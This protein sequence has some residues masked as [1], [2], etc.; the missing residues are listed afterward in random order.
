M[1]ALA[2]LTR[3]IFMI[4]VMLVLAIAAAIELCD[5]FKRGE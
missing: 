3:I 4:W 1:T 2:Y 5:T